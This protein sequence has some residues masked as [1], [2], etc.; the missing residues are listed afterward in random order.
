MKW[1]SVEEERPKNKE[2]I[3]AY[4]PKYKTIFSL[5]VIIESWG[6]YE[7][8]C[9][10]GHGWHIFDLGEISHWMPLPKPPKDK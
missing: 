6:P 5:E 10:C 7:F 3:L 1:I 9:N 4:V 2:L 8:D